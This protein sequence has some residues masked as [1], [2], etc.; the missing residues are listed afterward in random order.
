MPISSN[1]FHEFRELLGP[2][3]MG[4]HLFVGFHGI[5]PLFRMYHLF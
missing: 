4:F 1:F 3:F 5:F 2:V